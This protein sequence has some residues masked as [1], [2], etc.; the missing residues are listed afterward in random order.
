MLLYVR[1]CMCNLRPAASSSTKRHI[2]G[3]LKNK[4]RSFIKQFVVS[5][6]SNKLSLS[7]SIPTHQ[8]NRRNSWRKT[9]DSRSY[10]W[11]TGESLQ[12]LHAVDFRGLTPPG[13]PT[14]WWLELMLS[15][16]Y[17]HLT[18][19]RTH[20]HAHARTRTAF[21]KSSSPRSIYLKR[22]GLEWFSKPTA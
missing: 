7:R 4:T 15:L 8:K 19:T 10:K 9:Q 2:R 16:L 5:L 3:F 18:H 20:M 11:T 22:Y 6:F 13:Y 21:T 12:S 17:F 1:L 14:S